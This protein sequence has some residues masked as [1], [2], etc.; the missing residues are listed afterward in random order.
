LVQ[1]DDSSDIN[2]RDSK[3]TPAADLSPNEDDDIDAPRVAQ[4]VDED[5]LDEWSYGGGPSNKNYDRETS[6]DDDEDEHSNLVCSHTSY[7]FVFS[8]VLIDL[9]TKW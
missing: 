6:S 3:N 2:D 7:A 4:W 8:Q 5:D 9:F 1:Q